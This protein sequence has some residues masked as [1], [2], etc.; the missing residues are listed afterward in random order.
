MIKFFSK[1]KPDLLLHVVN[2]Y[3]DFNERKDLAD[4][5]Y[6]IQLASLKFNKGKTFRP[7][8]HIWK[9]SIS[10]NII[11]QESW[12]VIDG[13]VKVFFY[14]IDKKLLCTEI[15]KKGDSSITFEGGH[16]YEFL[17]DNTHVYEFKTGPY[18]GIEKDKIFIDD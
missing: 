3:K 17:E 7:H 9:P 10:K 11:A 15:L 18:E 13:S 14:D 16:N 4:P 5:K 2:R 12:V 8:M 6:F 1:N